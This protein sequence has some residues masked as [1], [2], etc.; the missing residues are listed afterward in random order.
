MSQRHLNL[1]MSST[2]PFIPFKPLLP[3]FYKEQSSIAVHLVTQD[4]NLGVILDSSIFAT[5]KSSPS[6]GQVSV[7]FKRQLHL[8]ASIFPIVPLFNTDTTFCPNDYNNLLYFQLI[9][10]FS[11]L[12]TAQPPPGDLL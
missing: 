8:S 5:H 2:Q 12:I 3:A 1:Q 6:A 11:C 7:T 4:K 10:L 9:L